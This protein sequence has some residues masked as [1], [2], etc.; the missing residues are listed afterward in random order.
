[1]KH[2]TSVLHAS[3]IETCL[4]KSW[5]VWKHVTVSKQRHARKSR[6]SLFC[7]QIQS[8]P[9][10]STDSIKTNQNN[11]NNI[12]QQPD[13]KNVPL[14]QKK[15]KISA[16]KP[17]DYRAA[18]FLQLRH[19]STHLHSNLKQFYVWYSYII[20]CKECVF[21]VFENPACAKPENIFKTLSVFTSHS[22]KQ[23]GFFFCHNGIWI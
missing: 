2:P 4:Q 19:D 17:P 20:P 11:F 12:L 15:L 21:L 1:M 8:A 18:G 6:Q 16:A 3:S 22:L 9:F 10:S 7:L 23:R 14:W 5:R 13:K